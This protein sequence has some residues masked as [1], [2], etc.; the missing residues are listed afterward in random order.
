MVCDLRL[1]LAVSSEALRNLV[2]EEVGDC[3]MSLQQSVDQSSSKFFITIIIKRCGEALLTGT[4][5]ATYIEVSWDRGGI[6]K[7]LNSPMR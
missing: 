1:T 4:A 2:L 6:R 3:L 5:S 7:I